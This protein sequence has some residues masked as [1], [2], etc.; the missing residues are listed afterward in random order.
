MK[1]SIEKAK[2]AAEAEANPIALGANRKR[3]PDLLA[4]KAASDQEAAIARDAA[5]QAA[6][7]A[8]YDARPDDQ[9][10]SASS[11]SQSNRTY[12]GNYISPTRL[13]TDNLG[14]DTR[15]YRSDF[16]S[17]MD[18]DKTGRAG[19]RRE[20]AGLP[21]WMTG[22]EPIVVPADGTEATPIGD[23]QPGA[24]LAKPWYTDPTSADNGEEIY[25]SEPWG[26]LGTGNYT[27]TVKTEGINEGSEPGTITG[28]QRVR[29]YA[30]SPDGTK[31][32]IKTDNQKAS[33]DWDMWN[34]PLNPL[35]WF[36]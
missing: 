2:A 18:A 29:T 1:E 27:I 20:A 33:N 4:A 8:A 14:P 31:L 16:I 36:N 9:K 32:L 3:P 24:D 21:S 28:E 10:S 19:P 15:D 7:Q 5:E 17:M 30:T 11:S 23:A 26:S 6:A 35:S 22:S 12:D 34:N 13:E 25:L